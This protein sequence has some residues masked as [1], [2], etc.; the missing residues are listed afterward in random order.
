MKEVIEE[1]V[2]KRY[3]GVQLTKSHT[4]VLALP[5]VKCGLLYAVLATYF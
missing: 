3:E 4:S 1:M 5:I 2:A